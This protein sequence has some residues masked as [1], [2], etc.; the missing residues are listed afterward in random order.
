MYECDDWKQLYNK[1]LI[2]TKIENSDLRSFIYKLLFNALNVENRFNNKK[3]ICFFCETNKETCDHLFFNCKQVKKKNSKF[4]L[5]IS[6][7]YLLILLL[8][9]FYSI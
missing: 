2:Q 4:N 8:L 5:I 9:T 6:K 3:N 7:L 1:Q